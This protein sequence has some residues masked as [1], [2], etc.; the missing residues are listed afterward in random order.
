V[1][2]SLEEGSRRAHLRA[3]HFVGV[4]MKLFAACCT[5]LA[6]SLS[7]LLATSKTITL[8]AVGDIKLDRAVAQQ[9]KRNDADYSV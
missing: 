8:A 3:H 4:V 7:P 6:V 9:M 1:A 5:L 2:A